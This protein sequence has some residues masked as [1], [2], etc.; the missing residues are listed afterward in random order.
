MSNILP[1]TEQETDAR[2]AD[3]DPFLRR[4]LDEGIQLF[5]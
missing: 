1:L 3:H 5:P 4:I 2:L